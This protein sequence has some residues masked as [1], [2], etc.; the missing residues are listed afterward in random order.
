VAKALKYE[1]EDKMKIAWVGLTLWLTLVVP[2]VAADD[3]HP[4]SVTEQG[5]WGSALKNPA[6]PVGNQGVVS[7][8]RPINPPSVYQ[9]KKEKESETSESRR[10]L[11]R[12]RRASYDYSH[13]RT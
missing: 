9:E 4:L 11:R 13:A 5:G 6:G 10:E 1:E 8:G 2:S 3:D 12:Q 7:T